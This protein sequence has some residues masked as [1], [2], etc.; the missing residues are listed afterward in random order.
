M[1]TNRDTPMPTRSPR[2]VISTPSWPLC[3]TIAPETVG[4]DHPGVLSVEQCGQARLLRN[5]GTDRE[6][7][8]TACRDGLVDHAEDIRPGHADGDQ[9]SRFGQFA[10]AGLGQA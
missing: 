5:A 1:V 8:A 3:E 7:R 2:V 9:L 4:A 10:D 6:K